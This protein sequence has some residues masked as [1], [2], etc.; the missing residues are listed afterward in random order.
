MSF[1]FVIYLLYNRIKCAAILSTVKFS[2]LM[3]LNRY[4]NFEK[5]RSTSADDT[6]AYFMARM[7]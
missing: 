1:I 6:G 3:S 5:D 7:S 4:F 2:L